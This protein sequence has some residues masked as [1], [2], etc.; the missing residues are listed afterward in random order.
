MLREHTKIV[1]V[2]EQAEEAPL[3]F[4]KNY[5]LHFFPIINFLLYSHKISFITKSPFKLLD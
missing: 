5:F 2:Q 1:L 3:H 4:L